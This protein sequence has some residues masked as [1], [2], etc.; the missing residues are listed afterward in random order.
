MI[1]PDLQLLCDYACV[2]AENPY[3]HPLEKKF[4]WTDI[5]AGKLYRYDPA[6]GNHEV[7]Y[8][9]RVVGGF[10]M[11]ADGSLLLFMDRGS[12]AIWK[13]GSIIR[14]ILE[15]I[16]DEVTTRFNDVIA[17]PQGRVYCGTMS[18]KERPGR[19]YRLDC[20]GSLH[21]LLEGIGCSN[22]MGFSLDGK[23]L[24]YTDSPK[25]EIYT[26]DY[27]R[28]TGNISNQK[29]LVKTE[30]EGGVPDGM[31][32]DNRGNIWSTRWNGSCIVNYSLEGKEI[33]RIDM[34]VK[35]VSSLV[36]GDE[37]YGSMYITTAGG[38]NKQALGE[39]AGGV[40]RL[41]LPG[42]GGQA[43]FVSRVGV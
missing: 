35:R 2:C 27:D 41:R 21:L 10:T 16:P 30:E 42:V 22:G 39:K 26:F 8:Q 23:T 34:P 5:P 40:F 17:D 1:P 38:E 20:D 19:L 43:E 7:C 4:Y 12:V 9:G 13:D 3:W 14:Y 25:R 36:F 18:T 6:N 15:D 28:A 24:Y 37:D 33:Q 32:L 11:Q 31:T 29:V